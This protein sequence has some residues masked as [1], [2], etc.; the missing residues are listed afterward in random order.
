MKFL[1]EAY[2]F[3]K[4]IS[5]FKKKI[6]LTKPGTDLVCVP[7]NIKRKCNSRPSDG[8]YGMK[9]NVFITTC[10]AERNK[11]D[12]E[13]QGNYIEFELE[14]DKKTMVLKDVDATICKPKPL[15]C[16]C[17]TLLGNLLPKYPEIMKIQGYFAANPFEAGCKCYLGQA[18]KLDFRYV[19]IFFE[20][21]ECK[22]SGKIPF[23][24][25]DYGKVCEDLKKLTKQCSDDPKKNWYAYGIITA[26]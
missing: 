11:D 2:M 14:D 7:A 25:K 23:D 10:S 16:H 21:K 12:W 4:N 9:P 26:E 18:S 22:P 5:I 6:A 13:K 24:E 20:K 1:E 19:Q 8:K 3:C 17:S 15:G